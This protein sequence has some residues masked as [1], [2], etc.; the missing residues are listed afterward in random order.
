MKSIISVE[1]LVASTTIQTL[2]ALFAPYT[3]L[4]V[5]LPAHQSGSHLGFGFVVFPTL[6]T[7]Q[8]AMAALNGTEFMGQRLFL[9]L[10]VL[11]DSAG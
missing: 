1:N 9:S 8:Q 6:S 11:P 2:E 10:L 7:A 3:P 5:I 4:H